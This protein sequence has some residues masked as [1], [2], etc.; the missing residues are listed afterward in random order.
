ME[1]LILLAL[2]ATAGIILVLSAL[3]HNFAASAIAGS[4][5]IFLGLMILLGGIE[6]TS[7]TSA[8]AY[9]ANVTISGSN[10]SVT[11][12]NTTNLKT[13]FSS[14]WSNGFSLLILLFGIAVIFM[15]AV[16]LQQGGY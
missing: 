9:N 2:L 1:L 15:G 12:T 10:Q 11:I 6:Y 7:G 4:F 5:F 8:M 16:K 13:S 3:N 14:S